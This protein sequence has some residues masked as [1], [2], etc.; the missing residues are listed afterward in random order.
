MYFSGVDAVDYSLGL[1]ACI[2]FLKELE[3]CG[4]CLDVAE[5]CD[6]ALFLCLVELPDKTVALKR[7]SG[8]GQGLLVVKHAIDEV[9]D[10]VL[11]LLALIVEIPSDI[12]RILAASYVGTHIV[13]EGHDAVVVLVLKEAVLGVY[14]KIVNV[15]FLVF[16]AYRL[17]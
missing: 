1:F 10:L 17:N 3:I 13:D 6:N 8:V 4:L 7:T 2:A 9:I 14:L 11:S 12:A 16:N 5:V 15:V